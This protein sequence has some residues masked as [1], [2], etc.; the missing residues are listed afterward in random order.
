MVVI[1]VEVALHGA[2]GHE[3]IAAAAMDGAEVAKVLKSSLPACPPTRGTTLRRSGKRRGLH[4]GVLHRAGGHRSRCGTAVGDG[5]DG[6]GQRCRAAA[7]GQKREE[8]QGHAAGIG[9]SPVQRSQRGAQRG[10]RCRTA[11]CRVRQVAVAVQL[12]TRSHQ[13]PTGRVVRVVELGVDQVLHHVEAG[14]AARRQW[15]VDNLLA[16]IDQLGTVRHGLRRT[17]LR[18]SRNYRR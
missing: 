8:T 3:N 14:R 13:P 15:P 6:G 18:G 16:G 4:A 1:R 17:A 11:G 2:V 7:A 12:H 9:T 10:Q 5:A